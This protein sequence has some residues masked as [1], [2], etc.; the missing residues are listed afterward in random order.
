MAGVIFAAPSTL[1]FQLSSL[2][3]SLSFDFR[4]NSERYKF[5]NVRGKRNEI[6]ERYTVPDFV[7]Q[8][9]TVENKF[10]LSAGGSILVDRCYLRWLC[11]HSVPFSLIRKSSIPFVPESPRFRF[12]CLI[13][14]F[15]ANRAIRRS[16]VERVSWNVVKIG[17]PSVYRT[18]GLPF[19]SVYL[20][21]SICLS[22]VAPRALSLPCLLK[23]IRLARETLDFDR[24]RFAI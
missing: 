21:R 23:L 11:T 22:A 7:A 10:R 4:F 8:G 3:L 15:V 17:S 1:M 16:L 5:A 24:F 12:P 13:C 14:H 9:K 18:K 6:F 19:I 20:S 2:S